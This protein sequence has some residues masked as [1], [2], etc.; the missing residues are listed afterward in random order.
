VAE[1]IETITGDVYDPDAVDLDL[2]LEESMAKFNA[3][4]A[5]ETPPAGEGD[6]DPSPADVPPPEDPPKETVSEP[7]TDPA[8]AS[9]PAPSEPPKPDPMAILQAEREALLAQ[10]TALSGSQAAT[11]EQLKQ[12]AEQ[13]KQAT[14]PQQAPEPP[15][16]AE[17]APEQVFAY[18]DNK[19]VGLEKQV[20]EAMQNDPA[21]A[22]ALIS[23][24]FKTQRQ[25][26]SYE[27]KVQLGSIQV[28][29]TETITEKAVEATQLR[30]EFDTKR[31]VIMNEYPQLAAGPNRDAEFHQEVMDI[32]QPLY[33]SGQDPI[34]ALEKA[35]NLVAAAKGVKSASQLAAEASQTKAAEAAEAERKAAEAKLAEVEAELA[36]DKGTTAADRKT[37]AVKRNLEAAAV[38]PPNLATVSTGVSNDAKGIVDKYDFDTMSIDEFARIPQNDLDKIE[39]ALR[40]HTL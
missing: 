12:V 34:T 37:D 20:A 9:E 36:K 40:L 10:I 23:E 21:S 29:D 14:A 26:S 13:L 30:M 4:F 3:A 8:T 24:L 33:K 17:P 18:L 27:T 11:Q 6:A 2:S 31:A 28:P 15:K 25:L 38:T 39:E 35:V 5:D 16:P 19:I 7:K 32:Y 22:P 1:P